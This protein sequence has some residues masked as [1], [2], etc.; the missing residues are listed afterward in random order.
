MT[1]P[2]RYE[3]S[4]LAQRGLRLR[5]E[6]FIQSKAEWIEKQRSRLLKHNARREEAF[7]KRRRVVP[8]F[9]KTQEKRAHFKAH[10][11]EA[12]RM[13]SERVM[14]FYNLYIQHYGEVKRGE[15]KVKSQSSRW[16]SCSRKGNLNFNYTLLFL[17]P[18]ERDYVIVHE[19]CHL[20]EFNH[21]ASFWRHVAF[22]VPD[23]MRIRK[24]MKN[25]F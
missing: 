2:K 3:K 6:K 13:I 1:A 20:Y 19:I 25:I 24:G 14:Y 21:G 23:Y 10:K 5:I 9:S 16:G 18:E 7:A 22:V 8:T 11:D 15:I 12:L 17:E 4:V